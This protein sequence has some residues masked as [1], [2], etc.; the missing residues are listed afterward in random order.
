MKYFKF[1]F[2]NSTV[3]EYLQRILFICLQGENR[4][5]TRLMDVSLALL[6]TFV[7]CVSPFL[8]IAGAVVGGLY[9]ATR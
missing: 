8:G 9:S 7:G 6:D 5:G 1:I 3:S 4:G 2:I